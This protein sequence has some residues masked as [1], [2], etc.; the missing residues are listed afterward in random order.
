MNALVAYTPRFTCIALAVAMLLTLPAGPVMAQQSP[1]ATID[2]S[3]A[4]KQLP[5]SAAASTASAQ[6]AQAGG[7]SPTLR[8]FNNVELTGFV[9]MYYSYNFNKPSDAINKLY[10]FNTQH[11]AF[12]FNLAEVALIKAPTQDSRAGF[13]LDFDYGPAAAM[14][15]AFEP[16]KENAI[17]EHTQQAYVSY[18]APGR[19]VQFDFGKFVTQHGAEVIETKDNWNYS[20]SLLFAWAIPYYHTGARLTVP[21]N[22]KFTFGAAVVNGWNNVYENNT[23]KTIGLQALIKPTA[24]V[25]IVQNYMGGP[26]QSGNNDDW[27]HLADTTVTI[28]ATPKV[29]VMANYDYGREKI[30]GETLSWQGAAGYLKYQANDVFAL[31]PRIEWFDDTDGWATIGDTITEFTL[32][33]EVKSAAGLVMRAEYRGDFGDNSPFLKKAVELVN[34]QHTFTIGFIYAFSSK[35]P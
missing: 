7:E 32:T 3:R 20:R 22:D 1:E 23:G 17:L 14:V 35:T 13:R 4:L 18:L 28:T 15:N 25:T 27:R 24:S 12:S 31:I 2:W 21:V 33:A 8:F 34:S 11:N 26:E 10:N 6:A 5:L 30:S 16:G 29:S 9:D 19:G